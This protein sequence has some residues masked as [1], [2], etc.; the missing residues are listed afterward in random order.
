MLRSKNISR[1]NAMNTDIHILWPLYGNNK[2]ILH[3]YFIPKNNIKEFLSKFKNLI[4]QHKTNILNITIRDLKPDSI[5][6]LPYATTDMFAAVCLFSQHQ[7][8]NEEIAMKKF[9]EDTIDIV[10]ELGGTFYLPYRLHY[11]KKQVVNSYPNILNWIENKNRF[12][13]KQIFDSQFYTYIKALI[14]EQA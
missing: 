14:L 4:L 8:Q 3:E 7:N 13:P 5:S 2:D 11:G 9:T 10:N 12:D 1:N 6:L